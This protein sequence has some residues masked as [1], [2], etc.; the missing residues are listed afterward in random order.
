MRDK[1]DI[2]LRIAD[3]KLSL[4]VNPDEEQF[5]REVAVEVNKVYDAYNSRIPGRSPQ[6][7]LAKVALLFARGYLSMSE[8]TKE[9][10]QTLDGLD[11]QLDELLGQV[12]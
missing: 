10:E 8:Q 5:L 2:N 4:T 11:R 12:S 3:T 9:V 7:V 1:L 6:E